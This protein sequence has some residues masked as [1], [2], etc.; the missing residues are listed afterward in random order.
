MRSPAVALEISGTHL[1]WSFSSLFLPNYFRVASLH[2]VTSRIGL[3]CHQ[4]WE[5]FMGFQAERMHN[6][7]WRSVTLR[8]ALEIAIAEFFWNGKHISIERKND[9]PTSV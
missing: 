4:I 5:E 9:G 3:E 8:G 7:I 6:K 2:I 1:C